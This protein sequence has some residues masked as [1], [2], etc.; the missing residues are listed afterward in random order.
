ME[1]EHILKLKPLNVS[2][3]SMSTVINILNDPFLIKTRT[4]VEFNYFI[5]VKH[6][7]LSTFFS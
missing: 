6:L 7:I 4:Q 5:L 1:L 2:F 3:Q